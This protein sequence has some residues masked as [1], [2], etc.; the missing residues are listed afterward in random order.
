MPVFYSFVVQDLLC[1]INVQHD[2]ASSR[3]GPTG[4]QHVYQERHRTETTRP[5]IMHT[6]NPD[7][8]MLNTAQMR[9]ALHL[10]KFR[11]PSGGLQSDDI[12]KTSAEAELS[13]RKAPSAIRGKGSRGRGGEPWGTGHTRGKGRAATATASAS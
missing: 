7:S 10:Q 11:V 9:D 1:T 6:N 4:V 2:C 8:M 13:S 5:V 3:C 12:L